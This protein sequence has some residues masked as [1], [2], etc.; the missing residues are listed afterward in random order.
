MSL[1]QVRIRIRLRK[2]GLI[3]GGEGGIDIGMRLI[4]N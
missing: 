1:S 2:Y 3:R 4:M